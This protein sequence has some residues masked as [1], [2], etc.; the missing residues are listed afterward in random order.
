MAYMAW[1]PVFLL[2]KSGGEKMASVSCHFYVN[3]KQS[4]EL[5]LRIRDFKK[6]NWTILQFYLFQN[7]HAIYSAKNYFFLDFFSLYLINQ[8]KGCPP[9]KFF[10]MRLSPLFKFVL[11]S[12]GLQFILTINVT[13]SYQSCQI[14]TVWDSF[15]SRKQY[16]SL[17]R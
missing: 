16:A 3:T 13:S 7:N 9:P 10:R 15:W 12:Q 8:I 2:L 17:W 5:V 4:H 1:L 11:F 6:C 14:L